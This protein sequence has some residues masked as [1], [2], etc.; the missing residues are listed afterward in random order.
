MAAFVASAPTSLHSHL[1]SASPQAS[2]PHPRPGWTIG[3][4]SALSLGAVL[5]VKGRN[6]RSRR[7]WKAA[8]KAPFPPSFVSLNAAATE[9]LTEGVV[10]AEERAQKINFNRLG[11]YDQQ[12]LE[13][14]Y[15]ETLWYYYSDPKKEILSKE[16]Y[17]KLTAH[18]DKKKSSLRKLQP[19]EVRFI[20][21]SIAYYRGKPIM[22]DG[23]YKELRSK[24]SKSG[25][26]KDMMQLIMAERSKRFLNDDEMKK[27]EEA[28]YNAREYNFNS[29]DSYALADLEELY[30]DSLWCFYREKRALL[31]DEE[32]D[33]LKKVLYQKGSRFPTLKRFEVAFVEASI[34]WYRGEPLMSEEEFQ[35]LK[36]KVQASGQR[37]DVTAFLLYER[38]EQFLDEEQ[39]AAMKEEYDMLGISAVNLEQC[40]VAQMEE[41]Y[42]EALW[43]YYNDGTQLLSDRQFEKLKEELTW[44]GSGFPALRRD[45][46]EFVKATLSYHRGEALYTNEQWDELKAKVESAGM[47]TEVTAFLLYSK[48]QEVLDPDTFDKMQEEMAKLGVNVQKAGSSALEQTLNV[49]SGKLENDILQV[50]FMISALA[51][52]PTTLAINLV[53]AVGLAYD[54][55]FVPSADW[56]NVLSVEFVPLFVIG[57][58]TGLLW[59]SWI[60]AFLDLQN[61]EILVG[62]CPSCG[63]PIKLFSGGAAPQKNVNYA[64]G[65]CGCKMVLDT[66]GRQ[67]TMAGASAEVRDTEKFDWKKTWEDV[68]GAARR[69]RQAAVQRLAS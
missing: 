22:T 25:R 33:T 5:A 18:L 65:Q 12:E 21:A 38:G 59:T 15:I 24:V 36:V 35:D 48:G 27:F 43:A 34:A 50:F 11:R 16:N 63:S 52:V 10:D 57:I 37:K 2:H 67:I 46:I 51:S 23:D 30:I 45:E 58:A 7:P 3:S 68:K 69:A 61:P 62:T 44:Q 60:L 40:T 49:T 9:L 54:W 56:G 66:E 6:L 42:V 8:S 41:M 14:V 29:L 19:D 53:W 26:R 64:C 13:A 31:S 4:T 17:D 1:Q 39:Y 55:S 47:R 32:F 20:E 28:F